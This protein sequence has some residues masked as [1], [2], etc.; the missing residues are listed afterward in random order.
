MR[1]VDR[2][3]AVV[4]IGAGPAG[5]GAAARLGE[6][7]VTDVVVLDR[8]RQ[9]GGLPAQCG[10]R[11]FGMLRY[12]MPLPGFTYARRLGDR[13]RRAGAIMH[14]ETT[15][16]EI[17]RD[18]TVLATSPGEVVRYHAQAVVVAT[19]CRET[20]RPR[21]AP[22]GARAAGVFNT[23][24]VQRLVHL[25]HLLP[26]KEVV[27]VGSEDVGLMAVRL[28]AQSGARVRAVI[29]ESPYLLGYKANYLYS[30]APFRVPVLLGWR[31]AAVFGD[32]RV[33]GAVIEQIG[34][35]TRREL[36]CDGVVFAG[37]FLPESTLAREGGIPL[38]RGTGGP[39]V[40]QHLQTEVPGIFACG[41]VLHGAESADIA[42]Q[43]GEAAGEAVARFLRGT[44]PDGGRTT[45]RPGQQV[46]AVT[47]QVL[48]A[49]D[50]QTVQMLIRPSR[51]LVPAR[52]EVT[53]GD[54][55]IA[56][57]WRPWGV[58][59]RSLKIK[60]TLPRDP[61]RDEVIVSLDGR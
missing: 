45:V 12:W 23:A 46:S 43:E 4:I 38:D 27:I 35:G 53:C 52:V 60:L 8:E 56:R 19:G 44:L 54:D 50:E 20:P 33:T 1:P 31:L 5:L 32:G 14:L 9:P 3:V 36:S 48:V 51:P 40:D 7:G 39:R 16:L 57:A 26:A 61:A 22:A 59:H 55:R 2:D 29:D 6:L 47:P 13:A 25:H 17:T 42:L 18:R 28:F 37:R 24:V 41:N 30:V 21:R 58:P 10:H 49:G 15:V 34:T 11:G